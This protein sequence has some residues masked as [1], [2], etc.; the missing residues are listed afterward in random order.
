MSAHSD[1]LTAELPA[2]IVQ[3]GQER[4][5]TCRAPLASDQRYCVECGRRLGRARLPFM[6]DPARHAGAVAPVTSHGPRVSASTT[7]VAGVGTL[8]LALGVGVLIGRSAPSSSKGSSP[9]QVLAAPGTSAMGTAGTTE[10]SA[11]AEASSAAT[12]SATATSS[13]AGGKGGKAVVKATKTG[14]PSAKVVKVG[15]P[16]K[17]PGYEKG[18]FTGN[19][20][21]KGEE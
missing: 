16:G 9:V 14:L 17:G 20:F 19:F 2:V 8:L 6:D 15:S 21:G 3:P 11:G 18:R 5:A 4:C 1:A 12:P 10:G 7:L 13:V